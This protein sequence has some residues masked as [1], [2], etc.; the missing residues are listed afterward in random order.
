M[1]RFALPCLA[2]SFAAAL[3]AAEDEHSWTPL[4]DGA[5]KAIQAAAAFETA[6]TDG[7]STHSANSPWA[8]HDFYR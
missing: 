5:D 4:R 8:G 6:Q 3:H 2:L 7:F 1:R